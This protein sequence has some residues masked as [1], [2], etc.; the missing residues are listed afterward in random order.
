MTRA[1]LYLDSS[2][3]EVLREEL[4]V[5]KSSHDGTELR[6]S[7]ETLSSSEVGRSSNLSNNNAFRESLNVT[8]IANN[9]SKGSCQGVEVVK[10]EVCGF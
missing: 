5:K 7:P 8:S 6:D 3:T 9:V 10:D 1:K 4:N 2:S